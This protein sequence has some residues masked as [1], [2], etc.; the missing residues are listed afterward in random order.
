[1]IV[2]LTDNGLPTAITNRWQTQYRYDILDNF[3]G[4]TDSQGN[5]KTFAY[6]ALSRKIFMNDLDRGVMQWNYN[7]ASNLRNSIDA[8]AQQIT[9]TYDK[10]NR[11]LTEKYLDGLPLPPWRAA[12][13]NPVVSTNYSVIY[14]YDQPVPNLDAGDT[15][16]VTARNTLGKLAWVEDLSG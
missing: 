9:Y 5:Q 8:K 3:L 2:K 16:Q 11:L 15:T 12:S 1:E 13:L 4:Y 14:H 6:D 10:V 7:L